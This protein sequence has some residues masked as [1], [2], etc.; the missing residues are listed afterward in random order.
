MGVWQAGHLPHE[1]RH[2]RPPLIHVRPQAHA[3]IESRS[4]IESRLP[5]IFSRGFF[6]RFLS[7]IEHRALFGQKRGGVGAPALGSE[8]VLR[9]DDGLRLHGDREDQFGDDGR[10]VS[11]SWAWR[12]GGIRE[13]GVTLFRIGTRREGALRRRLWRWFRVLGELCAALRAGCSGS[14]T[15]R[16]VHHK[17]PMAC[18]TSST[19]PAAV[20][21]SRNHFDQSGPAMHAHFDRVVQASAV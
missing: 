7:D 6:R 5:E 11:V 19:R 4:L 17:R 2:F 3:A 18:T 1:G 14:S 21:L 20:W 15:I 10:S 12:I 9:V 8:H 16:T 13:A